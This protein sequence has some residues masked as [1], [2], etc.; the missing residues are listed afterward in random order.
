MSQS[1]KQSIYREQLLDHF[2]NPRG[3]QAL[4]STDIISEGRNPMCGDEID[5]GLHVHENGSVDI[6]FRGRGCSVCLASASMM[7]ETLSGMDVSS[8]QL[9]HSK[10]VSWLGNR[11]DVDIEYSSVQA[12]DAVRTLPARKRC[13]MLAWD[14]LAKSLEKL[15]EVNSPTSIDVKE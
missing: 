15:S 3:K 14:A 11:D 8:A 9:A 7:V 2:H 5:V 6:R 10:I 4:E 1:N 12:L 13:V